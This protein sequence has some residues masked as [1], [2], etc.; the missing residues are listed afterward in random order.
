MHFNGS[1][2]DCHAAL[3]LDREM[4]ERTMQSIETMKRQFRLAYTR[5][6]YL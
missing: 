6:S 3:V 2:E 1:M 4:M 5:E